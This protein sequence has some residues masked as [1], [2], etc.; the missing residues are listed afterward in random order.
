MLDYNSKITARLTIQWLTM[1]IIKQRT[2]LKSNNKTGY[3]G[4]IPYYHDF[5]ARIRV[6]GKVHTL[7]IY[8]TAEA[9]YRAYLKTAHDLKIKI[10]V[11]K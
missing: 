5:M 4:V 3:P 10:T 8:A 7:G 6:G 9:A 11:K 2:V 1:R